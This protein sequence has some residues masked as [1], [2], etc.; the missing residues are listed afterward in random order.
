MKRQDSG[1]LPKVNPNAPALPKVN[2]E[3]I[4]WDSIRRRH[5][6]SSSSSNRPSDVIQF[7]NNV[8]EGFYPNSAEI[9]NITT[10][11]VYSS[12]PDDTYLEKYV[13]KKRDPGIWVR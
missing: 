2:E 4:A 7:C 11:Y 6:V 9:K 3:P 12:P 1:L 5:S 10:K 13:L 8:T